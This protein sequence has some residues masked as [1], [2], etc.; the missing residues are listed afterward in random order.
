MI[1]ISNLTHY[2]DDKK[3]VLE[4]INLKIDDGRVMG[5]VG[6]NGAGKSTLLR[7]IA[8]VYLPKKGEIL[9]DGKKPSEVDLRKD[10]FFLADDPYFTNNDTCKSLKTLYSV[11]FENFNNEVFEEIIGIFK[12]P[13]TK[14]IR[15]FSKG[16]RRQVYIA[17]A[18]AVSPKYLLLDEAF[19]GL[20]PLAKIRFK[21]YICRFIKEQGSTVIVSS[22]S[23]SELSDFCDQYVMIDGKKII[24]TGSEES[25]ANEFVKF[26]VAFNNSMTE[27]EVRTT[28]IEITSLKI[29]GRVVTIVARGDKSQ[30]VSEINK[31]N[32]LFIDELELNFE[33]AFFQD[34]AKKTGAEVDVKK[35][36]EGGNK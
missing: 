25:T 13:M 32:P 23:L 7:L 8:G 1:E 6:I 18:F 28:N 22:H 9:I 2:Y 27:E 10:L 29:V 15:S 26:Q 3:V 20:D 36:A 30:V 16:M 31:L 19:D 12:L 4:D 17:L 14:K 33:E 35:E 5:L 21:N 24:H 34:L 11:F